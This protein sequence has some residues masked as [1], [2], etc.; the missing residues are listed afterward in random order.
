[1]PR[2]SQCLTPASCKSRGRLSLLAGSARRPVAQIL[3]VTKP[4][5]CEGERR[6]SVLIAGYVRYLNREERRV[7]SFPFRG[8]PALWVRRLW[9]ASR[10]STQ[11]SGLGV[12]FLG[13]YVSSL[14]HLKTGRP[15][16]ADVSAGDDDEGLDFF[17]DS[18]STLFD[19]HSP[20]RGQPGSSLVYSHAGLLRAP[21]SE[22]QTA[23]SSISFGIPDH[24]GV[25]T[26]LFA[27][28]Q[29]DAGW[30]LAN[31]IVCCSTSRASPSPWADVRGKS[32]VEVGAGTGLP[33]LVA[34]RMGAASV[35]ITDYPDEAILANLRSNI[36][37]QH[38]SMHGCQTAVEGLSW[39]ERDQEQRA[40]R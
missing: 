31:E 27:H 4:G 5:E 22:D 8:V 18:L 17:S 32:C 6:S 11:N 1:M 33:S 35:T 37:R 19:V 10:S 38:A 20:A 14:L 2:L 39:G 28:Y 21:N 23:S 16:M 40:L 7:G 13:T 3:K 24:D 29:W 30:D 25:S 12:A 26:K 15:F 36:S 34:H 9:S